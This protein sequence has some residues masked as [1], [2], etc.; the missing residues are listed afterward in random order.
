[1]AKFKL[2]TYLDRINVLSDV[3]FTYYLKIFKPEDFHIML[4]KEAEEDLRHYLT[5]FGFA[6]DNIMVLTRT[7]F[8]F[9]E[10]VDM[11]NRVKSEYLKRGYIVI[12]ADI[13]EIIWHPD[14]K[15]YI[16][17]YPQP[18]ICT[19]GIQI[20]Q[21]VDEDYLDASRPILDQRSWCQPDYY[22]YSKLCILKK[23]FKWTAGRHNKGTIPVDKSV[24]LIDIGKVCKKL[25]LEN[26]I[27]TT[28]IYKRIMERYRISSQ[29]S[30][31]IEYQKHLNKIQL[32][33]QEVKIAQI[34]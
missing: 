12:Y 34:F 2:I 27:K 7:H 33:P 10:N 8:G 19:N 21:N 18:F 11:Q 30:M 4:Y 24:Y 1:M 20:V 31:E 6:G 28:A 5:K 15:N 16:K 25:M 17:D 9:G 26:N 29:E 14:L 13:D 3:F 23:D 32:I 22:Y